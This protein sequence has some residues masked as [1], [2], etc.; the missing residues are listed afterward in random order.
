MRSRSTEYPHVEVNEDGVAVITGKGFEVR[1]LARDVRSGHSPEQLPLFYPGLKVAEVYSG[2]AYL[3][4]HE[5]G[6]GPRPG[7]GPTPPADGAPQDEGL[8]ERFR[9][10]EGEQLREAYEDE[11]ADALFAA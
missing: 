8:V 7:P 9:I 2:L 4:D 3:A 1:R 11:E 10:Y 6:V 5:G